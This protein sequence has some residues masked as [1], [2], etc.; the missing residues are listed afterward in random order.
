M[1]SVKIPGSSRMPNQSAGVRS[2]I[3]LLQ[4]ISLFWAAVRAMYS[5]LLTSWK[6]VAPVRQTNR[7]MASRA[8]MIRL[9]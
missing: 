8:F 4:M 5:G 6:A 9:E 3:T 2:S 7:E 1:D